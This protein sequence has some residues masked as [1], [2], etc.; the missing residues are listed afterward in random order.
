MLLENVVEFT[1]LI[2]GGIV[3]AREEGG[4]WGLIVYCTRVCCAVG[5][6]MLHRV[7]K[8]RLMPQI[9]PESCGLV[10][11]AIALSQLLASFLFFITPLRNFLFHLSPSTSSRI[12]NVNPENQYGMTS[13]LSLLRHLSFKSSIDY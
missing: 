4:S 8:T 11:K 5:T 1:Q 9:S 13:A 12:Q 3:L 2:Y 6:T 7:F 10:S